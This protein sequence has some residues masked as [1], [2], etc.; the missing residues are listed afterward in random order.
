MAKNIKLRDLLSEQDPRIAGYKTPSDRYLSKTGPDAQGNYQIDP[1][2][3]AV[4][5]KATA[6]DATAVKPAISPLKKNPLARTREEML[7]DIADIIYKSKGYIS[8][9]EQEAYDQITSIKNLEDWEFVENYFETEYG[10][11]LAS[12]LV[13]NNYFGGLSPG[14]SDPGGDAAITKKLANWIYRQSWMPQTKKDEYLDLIYGRGSADIEQYVDVTHGMFGSR[15]FGMAVNINDVLDL[16]SLTLDAIPVLGWIV[17]SGIDLINAGIF[18]F[19]GDYYN[20]GMRTIFAAVPGISGGT[21]VKLSKEA[22]IKLGEKVAI[23][24]EKGVNKALKLLPEE[25]VALKFLNKNQVKIANKLIADFANKLTN[26]S[27]AKKALQG[28][29]NL[30]KLKQ[31]D[32][33]Q[34]LIAYSTKVSNTAVAKSILDFIAATGVV[35]AADKALRL[36]SKPSQAEMDAYF[37]TASTDLAAYFKRMASPLA[38]KP[39]VEHVNTDLKL[40][41]ILANNTAI[42]LH[43]QQFDWREEQQKAKIKHAEDVAEESIVGIDDIYYWGTFA[44]YGIGAYVTYKAGKGLL[45]SLLGTSAKQGWGLLWDNGFNFKKWRDTLT[46]KNAQN[47]LEKYGITL[48]KTEFENMTRACV[49]RSQA[50]IDLVLSRVRSGELNPKEA[51]KQLRNLTPATMEKEYLALYDIYKKDISAT[52]SATQAGTAATSA[53]TEQAMARAQWSAQ[54]PNVTPEQFQTLNLSDRYYLQN[55]NPLA[56]YNYR[57]QSIIRK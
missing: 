56:K 47:A 36:A 2:L 17:S 19:K 21:A 15:G 57:T 12:Y 28:F 13:S 7:M 55:T 27:T 48:T 46:N 38:P 14:D 45:K 11:T 51:I 31:K 5:A 49:V 39:Y 24:T 10:K 4:T 3:A 41:S 26:S 35:T 50:E 34:S 53:G 8:D 16:V 33:I 6:K 20:A 32:L 37:K 29:K 40:T 25:L 54:Y 30:S 43:E 1:K 44:A 9:D 22:L 52:K 42:K 18:L 23:A